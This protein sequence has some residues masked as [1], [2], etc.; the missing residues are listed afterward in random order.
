[1]CPAPDLSSTVI[2][3]VNVGTFCFGFIDVKIALL[4]A[5]RSDSLYLV[6]QLAGIADEINVVGGCRAVGHFSVFSRVLRQIVS[7]ITEGGFQ[8]EEYRR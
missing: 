7:Q 1:M 5:T 6:Q 4:Q 2:S 3:S 8:L